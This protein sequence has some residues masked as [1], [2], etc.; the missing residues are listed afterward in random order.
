MKSA[1]LALLIASAAALHAA[2]PST[3]DSLIRLQGRVMVRGTANF[4]ANARIVVAKVGG[5][6]EDYRATLSD[7]RGWFTVGDLPAGSYRVHADA[8]GYLRSEYGRPPVAS[9][10]TPI[11][12]IEG[13]T[14]PEVTI[15][16]TPT[17]VIAGRVTDRGRPAP[18]VYVRAL[19]PTYRDGQRSLSVE[20]YAITDEH[21]D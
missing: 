3:A 19:K 1:G 18:N 6:V 5:P 7:S 8:Q 16:M 15:W 2:E 11:V 13:G 12:L 21:G 14:P 4:V 9:A 20:E 10:G 17:G